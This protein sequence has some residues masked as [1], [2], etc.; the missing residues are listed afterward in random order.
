MEKG[1]LE[2]ISG[3]PLRIYLESFPKV[4]EESSPYKEKVRD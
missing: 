1:P 4:T 2:V 3:Y